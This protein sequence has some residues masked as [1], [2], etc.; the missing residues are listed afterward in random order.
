MLFVL[1]VISVAVTAAWLHLAVSV[2][3]IG[4]N[5]VSGREADV[6]NL[7]ARPAARLWMAWEWSRTWER[8][9]W[10]P[11]CNYTIS[12]QTPGHRLH[13]EG[14]PA[15]VIE[16]FDRLAWSGNVAPQLGW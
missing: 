8:P 7:I 5:W 6:A 15:G 14:H 3:F 2:V 1:P 10:R 11:W 9:V 16:Q 4:W 12:R 13:F